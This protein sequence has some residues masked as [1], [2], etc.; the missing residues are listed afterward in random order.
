MTGA[1]QNLSYFDLYYLLIAVTIILKRLARDLVPVPAT[2][3]R[4]AAVSR[5][6]TRQPVAIS[7][8]WRPVR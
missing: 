6:P 7:M 5:Q 8:Y 2:Q 3:P 1:F 4:P